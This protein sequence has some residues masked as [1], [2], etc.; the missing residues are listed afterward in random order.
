MR[1]HLSKAAFAYEVQNLKV[2][3]AHLF[4]RHNRYVS[5]HASKDDMAF[6]ASV[7]YDL[8]L[9][10][11]LEVN[12]TAHEFIRAASL[13]RVPAPQFHAGL[14]FRQLDVNLAADDNDDDP[15][16]QLGNGVPALSSAR[17]MER[18]VRVQKVVGCEGVLVPHLDVDNARRRVKHTAVKPK[19][20]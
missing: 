1:T 5:P 13:E 4:L 16:M 15:H 18:S 20:S 11:N 10:E 12:L 9:V 6:R 7:A 14:E 17:K 2:A 3:E 19:V 8:G